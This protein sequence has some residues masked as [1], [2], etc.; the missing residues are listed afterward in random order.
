MFEKI[1]L[2]I[3][4]GIV[5]EFECKLALSRTSKAMQDKDMLTIIPIVKILAHFVKNFL[6]SYKGFH[7]EWAS[8]VNL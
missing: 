5:Q 6:S 7:W 8:F 3:S 1:I 4:Y 2:V